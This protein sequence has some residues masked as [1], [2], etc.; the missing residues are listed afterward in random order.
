MIV[1]DSS[2]C[3]H[4]RV[5]D[6][7]ILCELLH[8]DQVAGCGALSCS[9]AHAIIPP[10]ETTLPHRLRVATELY[11][12]L[13]GTGR[14]HISAESRDVLAGQVVLIPPQKI[15]YIEN[16]GSSDLVFLCIVTPPW[17]EDDEELVP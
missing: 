7:S 3:L 8:P 14:M 5:I 9:V 13:S 1:R 4:Q 11:Y 16:T 2:T 17:K 12:I 6:R 15:Q 10:G